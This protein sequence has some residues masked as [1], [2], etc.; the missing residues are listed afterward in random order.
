MKRFNTVFIVD[1]DEIT[2][3][4]LSHKIEDH[5]FAEEYRSIKKATDA[6]AYLEEN[7]NSPQALPDLIFLDINMPEMNSWQF[8][9]RY[10][11]IAQS[12]SK[13]IH[14]CILTSSLFERDVERAKKHPRVQEYLTKP[15]QE[16]TLNK[17]LEKYAA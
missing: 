5:G 6:I 8:L 11:S 2:Q 4:L 13:K 16:D 15:I 12:I 17:L 3:F 10:E 1:D 14:I 9:E 7:K